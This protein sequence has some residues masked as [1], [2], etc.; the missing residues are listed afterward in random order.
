MKHYGI[1]GDEVRQLGTRLRVS[2]IGLGGNIFGRFS[3]EKET[4]AIFNE[5]KRCGIN[6]VDTADIYS[7]GASEK[8]IG[9]C[10]K[11][12]RDYWVI[13][14]KVGIPAKGA[15]SRLRG[16][17]KI[18]SACEASLKRLQIETIDLFQ[19]ESYHPEVSLDETL[20][21]IQELQKQGKIREFGVLNYT[22]DHL[23]ELR[24]VLQDFPKLACATM[25]TPYNVFARYAE[26][27]LIPL[28]MKQGISVLP[29]NVLARGILTEKYLKDS[30]P[31]GSR[32]ER[33]ESVRNAVVPE[34]LERVN[35]LKEV[36]DSQSITVS[37]LILA[38]TLAQR[39][40]A[41]IP[42]G[43]RNA[44]Q[45]RENTRALSIKLDQSIFDR[46]EEIIRY[47]SFFSQYPMTAE[48]AQMR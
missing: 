23:L 22:I 19:I 39:G 29:Y 27:R 44:E 32:A 4:L 46:I 37:Q 31:E 35:L 26:E 14:T 36:A 16:R 34:V 17:D 18:I 25:Q 24:S 8:V 2:P 1:G 47:T 45:V 6:F 7:E 9:K 42:L 41:S 15:C 13:A 38:W 30:L 5:A 12:D 33:S 20:T 3:D 11:T 10:V 48:I 21:A 40:V 28:C 43:M